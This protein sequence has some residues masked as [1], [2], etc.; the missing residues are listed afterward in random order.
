MSIVNKS[1]HFDEHNFVMWK[2]KVMV[3]LETMNFDMLNVVNSGPHVPVYQ[4][5]FNNALAGPME[6][7]PKTSYDD[8]EKRLISVDVKTRTIIRNSLPYHVCH[9]VQN[10]EFAQ[11]IME[12]LI[13]A[14]EG[15]V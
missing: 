8:D 3:V 14:Y 5:M 6:Q 15:T 2:S 12:M 1:T 13:V 10:Y 4:P 9:L 7:N 11:E